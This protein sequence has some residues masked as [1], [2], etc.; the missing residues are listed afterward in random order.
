M[1]A[2]SWLVIALGTAAI[3]W[4]CWYFFLAPRSAVSASATVPG[5]IPEVTITVKGGYDP[6]QI[7]V[8]AGRPVRLTFDRQET[9]SCSEEVVFPDFGV[10]QFLPAFQKTTIE[11]TP[12]AVGKYGFMCG[13]S[14][15][16]GSLIA[17]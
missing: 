5:A 3:A 11:V 6:A 9:S 16:H 4:V 14:M 13:M 8:R 17:E 2:T 10:K 12:P 7:R 1:T 15:L